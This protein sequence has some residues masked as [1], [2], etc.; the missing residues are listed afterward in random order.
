MEVSHR[1]P[2]CQQLQDEPIREA[3]DERDGVH[4]KVPKIHHTMARPPHR[5]GGGGGGGLPCGVRFLCRSA[6]RGRHGGHTTAAGLNGTR[7][8]RRAGGGKRRRQRR[9]R[10]GRTI[11]GGGAQRTHTLHGDRYCHVVGVL[12]KGG[13][14]HRI[15]GRGF[16]S[17]LNLKI[18]QP[19]LKILH[20]DGLWWW[21]QQRR[22]TGGFWDTFRTVGAPHGVGGR[23]MRA[24]L[25]PTSTTFLLPCCEKRRRRRQRIGRWGWQTSGRDRGKIPL[26]IPLPL[27]KDGKQHL[28]VG[29][30]KR[31][32]HGGEEYFHLHG[33]WCYPHDVPTA[34]ARGVLVVSM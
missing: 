12:S 23:S 1:F 4:A 24:V 33:R 31:D 11:F 2:I 20:N 25:V 6:R 29:L 8:R 17:I 7:A 21:W 34:I 28:A 10:R 22:V 13:Q 32:G 15:R 3:N 18:L 26:I 30:K 14:A 27:G 19:E 16:G 5:S 9:T